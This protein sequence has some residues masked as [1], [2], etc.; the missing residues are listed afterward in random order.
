MNQNLL[1]IGAGIYGLVAKEIA[2]SM[3]CF[4]RIDFVDDGA[5]KSPDG[6]RSSGQP[7]TLWS[8]PKAMPMWS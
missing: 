1:I 3:G 7:T 5:K 6:T 4:R 2:E 8:F